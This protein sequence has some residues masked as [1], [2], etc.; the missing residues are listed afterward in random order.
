[1]SQWLFS[2]ERGLVLGGGQ[3]SYLF[4]L[5][6]QVPS[7][8]KTP[9]N[10]YR[11]LLL[12][13]YHLFP[14]CLLLSPSIPPSLNPPTSPTQVSAQQVTSTLCVIMTSYQ[15]R[16]CLAASLLLL[17]FSCQCTG[18][19]QSQGREVGPFYSVKGGRWARKDAGCH[20]ECRSW[21]VGH[22]PPCKS[23][24]EGETGAH[25]STPLLGK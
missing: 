16:A 10:T 1:M 7:P 17:G 3:I 5:L 9:P 6:A 4:P 12:P 11:I 15:C 14:A 25:T 21:C 13:P 20:A 2:G 8:L 18:L 24:R 23:C 22:Q 19:H